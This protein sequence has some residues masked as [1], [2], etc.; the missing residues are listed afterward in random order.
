MISGMFCIS[1]EALFPQRATAMMD[2]GIGRCFS[3]PKNSFRSLRPSN[4]ISIASLSLEEYYTT[5][6]GISTNTQLVFYIST[7]D[8][9]TKKEKKL[10]KNKIKG[11]RRKTKC[12]EE[13]TCGNYAFRVAFFVERLWPF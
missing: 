5:Y 7:H 8:F 4:N 11:F 6:T 13:Y 2:Y 12:A 10:H 1:Q 3:I 9:L